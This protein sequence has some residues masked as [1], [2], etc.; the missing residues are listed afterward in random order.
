VIKGRVL[1][2]KGIA[3]SGAKVNADPL[4]GRIRASAIR[5]VETDSEGQ[6]LIDHLEW[7]KYLVFAMKEEAGFPNMAFLFYRGNVAFTANLTPSEPTTELQMRLGPK[8]GVLIGYATHRLNGA[9]VNVEVKLT[10]AASPDDWFS[11]SVAPSFRVLLPSSTNVLLEISAPGFKTWNPGH[12]LRLEPGAEMRL[13]IQLEPSHDPNL[14]PSKF[15]VPEGFT[16]WLL[17]DY[18]VKGVEP[19]PREDGVQIFKFPAS[20]ALSTSSAGPERGAEDEYFHYSPDGS[21]HQIPTDYRNGEGM[22]WGQHEGTRNGVLSQF[23]FFVGTEEQYKKFQTR[24]THPGPI[25]TP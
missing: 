24:M 11:T 15:L 3:L 19:V 4:D 9:P 12:P 22:I 16:G 8:A 5:Y 20:G 13:D 1:D 23:G 14:H 6:F 18:G 21:L 2:D 25:P 17:L 10:R 7:G